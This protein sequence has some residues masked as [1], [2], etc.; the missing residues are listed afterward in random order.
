LD[1]VLQITKNNGYPKHLITII[2]SDFTNKIRQ[3][4]LWHQTKQAQS[5]SPLHTTVH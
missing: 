2:N 4:E 5:G 3:K 1:T